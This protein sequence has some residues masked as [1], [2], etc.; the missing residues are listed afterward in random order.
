MPLNLAGNEGEGVFLAKSDIHFELLYLTD[1]T[2][3]MVRDKKDLE[4][5]GREYDFKKTLLKW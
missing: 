3:E 5:W 1:L 4:I 2:N